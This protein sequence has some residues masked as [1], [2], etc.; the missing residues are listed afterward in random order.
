MARLVNRA[1]DHSELIAT[2][3]DGRAISFGRDDPRT[4]LVMIMVPTLLQRSGL[5][6][7]LLPSLVSRHKFLCSSAPEW[8]D[9]LADCLSTQAPL[10]AR[11]LDRMEREMSRLHERYR[12]TARSRLVDAAELRIALPSLNRN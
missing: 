10:A 8:R 2:L 5:S 12:R 9:L 1:A 7:N 11:S 6:A 3:P 4:W